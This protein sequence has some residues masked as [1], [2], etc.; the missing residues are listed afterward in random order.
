MDQRIILLSVVT[1]GLAA[2][3]CRP[4]TGGSTTAHP[5]VALPSDP[6]MARI[7]LGAPP[8]APLALATNLTNPYEGDAV[9]VA[10]GKA[11]YGAMNCVYCHGAAGAGLIGPPLDSHG[12]RYGGAPAQ[13]YNSI[14][15]G[16]PQGMPGWGGSL[17]PDQI[18]KLVAY[19]ESLGGAVPPA[20]AKMSAI[21][22]TQPSTT[23][24]QAAEQDKADTAHQ[25]LIEGDKTHGGS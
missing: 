4:S 1:I 18:W 25:A 19:I 22:E 9:A 20:T 10:Q 24:P 3:A 11:L 12:W 6:T 16:R 17:P 8:G 5:P 23:G 15:D 21:A 14:H 2:A 7:P 13:I